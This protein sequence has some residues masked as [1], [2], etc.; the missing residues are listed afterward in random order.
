MQ[1]RHVQSTIGLTTIHSYWTGT[2]THKKTGQAHSLGTGTDQ[3][4]TDEGNQK[5]AV[6]NMLNSAECYELE[7]DTNL[8]EE[9]EVADGEIKENQRC[10]TQ[11]S[12]S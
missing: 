7:D 10:W 12:V 5:K 1:L 8:V 2:T 3:N 9:E 11:V 6:K 4:G